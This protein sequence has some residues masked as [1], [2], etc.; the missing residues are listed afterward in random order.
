MNNGRIYNLKRWK[1]LRLDYLASHPFCEM[2]GIGLSSEVDH[3]KP[4]NEG[5]D[6]WDESNFQALCHSCHSVK[7]ASKDHAFGNKTSSR[8]VRPRGCTIDGLPLDK[9]NEWRRQNEELKKGLIPRKN[10]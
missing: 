4:I 1:L 6:P 10:V 5:G 7:T 2:C 8:D 9:N 3:I